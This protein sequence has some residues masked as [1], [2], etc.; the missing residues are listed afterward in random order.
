MVLINLIGG[1]YEIKKALLYT[2][3]GYLWFIFTTKLD[4][5]WNL[6]I[7]FSLLLAY[8]YESDMLK[9]EID[10]IKTNILEYKEKNSLFEKNKNYRNYFVIGIMIITLIGT[11]LYE[12][13]KSVQYGGGKFSIVKYL[14]Y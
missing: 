14:F 7:I 8:L 2:F 11:L 5:H 6:I 4:I 13:K 3:I 9:H 1:I 10:I 12:R